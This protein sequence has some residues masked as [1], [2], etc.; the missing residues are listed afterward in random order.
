MRLRRRQ[1][2]RCIGT[3]YC[4]LPKKSWRGKTPNCSFSFINS[5]AQ[6]AW[7]LPYPPQLSCRLLCVAHRSQ[8]EEAT[9]ELEKN[10]AEQQRCRQSMTKIVAEK[11][12]NSDK[13]TEKLREDN[14]TLEL[15]N[16]SAH[17]SSIL[18]V[19]RTTSFIE[20]PWC[21]IK[22]IVMQFSQL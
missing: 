9:N 16:K 7:L 5:G 14:R 13:V 12:I 3:S 8:H 11:K 22:T 19:H 2:V 1:A 20:W 10:R 4:S 6:K 21:L 15:R 17:L 18:L